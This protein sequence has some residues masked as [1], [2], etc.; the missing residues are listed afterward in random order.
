M[1]KMER[2]IN[3]YKKGSITDTQLDRMVLSGLITKEQKEEIRQSK[4][5]A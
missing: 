2:Y 1:T 5:N 4:N 3:W